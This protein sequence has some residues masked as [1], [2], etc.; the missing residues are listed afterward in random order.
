MAGEKNQKVLIIDCEG[1]DSKSRSDDDRGKFEHSSS[2]FALAMSD[3]LIVNMWTSDVGRYTA[4]NYGVLKIVFEMNLKL[5]QQECAKKILIMLRDFDP[6]RNARDK[7]ES[8][9]LSD[10]H[11]IWEEIKKP[12]KYKDS[13]PEQFFK[14][15][16]IT[17]SHKVYLPDK[18][19][20]ESSELDRITCFHTIEYRLV[21]K[22]M[23][24]KF[25]F[26][27]AKR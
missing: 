19:N 6:K 4:S 2:L 18:F 25:L 1:T 23:L 11:K 17:L 14:F 9:I 3:V 5:F 7:I 16:F 10:I 26:Q 15:E 24:F 12:E 21:R 22:N 13:K 27:N 20:S 8:M